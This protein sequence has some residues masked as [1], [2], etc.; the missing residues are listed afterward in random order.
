MTATA[1]ESAFVSVKTAARVSESQR[2]ASG[3]G[4]T[5]AQLRGFRL[6]STRRVLRSELDR[7]LDPKAE[8]PKET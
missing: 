5:T 4:L 6:G 8:A 3:A 2:R 7:L 1:T